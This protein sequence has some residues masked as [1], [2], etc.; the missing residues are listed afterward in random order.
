[1]AL[2]IVCIASCSSEPTKNREEKL[3]ANVTDLRDTLRNTVKDT[4]KLAQM[5]ALVDQNTVEL[6]AGIKEYEKLRKEDALL[7]TNYNASRDEFKQLGDRIQY[8]RQEFWTRLIKVRMALAQ[9]ATGDEWKKIT[10]RDLT[11]LNN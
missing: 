3:Q 6:H 5:L 7:N 8:V 1:M 4:E 2:F 10:S 11:I 9:L